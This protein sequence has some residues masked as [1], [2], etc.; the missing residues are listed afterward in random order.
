MCEELVCIHCKDTFTVFE[1]IK[2]G[3]HVIVIPEG[4]LHYDC[5]DSYLG[6][7]NY[8]AEAIITDGKVEY[9]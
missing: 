9:I 6:D 7:R 5:F 4:L 2:E 3:D 8:T 1:P